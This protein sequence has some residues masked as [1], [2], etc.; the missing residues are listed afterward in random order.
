MADRNSLG[1]LGFIF[2]G[3]TLAVMLMAAT[4]VFSHLDG[5]FVLESAPTAIANTI[6]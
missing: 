3:V 4:V 5:H 2:G 1:F 6:R